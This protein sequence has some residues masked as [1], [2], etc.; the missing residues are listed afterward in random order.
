MV[1]HGGS[2]GNVLRKNR[3]FAKK[4][5]FKP[6]NHTWPTIMPN[7]CRWLNRWTYFFLCCL[8]KTC[9]PNSR[10]WLSNMMCREIPSELKVYSSEH[11]QPNSGSFQLDLAQKMP[12]GR[13]FQVWRIAPQEAV[14]LVM[15]SA[16]TWTWGG[17]STGESTQLYVEH[18]LAIK[19]SKMAHLSK[20]QTSKTHVRRFPE[21]G[22][23][24]N[25]WFIREHPIKMDD[26]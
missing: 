1:G 26:N 18:P 13:S 2:R 12:E 23:Y 5:A 15:V 19:S 17:T 24:N 21:I 11:H 20:S 16:T 6:F 4:L 3:R 9:L 14:F 7:N 25:G 8:N 10:N 22:L